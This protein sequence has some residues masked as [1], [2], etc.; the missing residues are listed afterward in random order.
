MCIQGPT[1]GHAVSLDEK[2]K[3]CEEQT[4]NGLWLNTRSRG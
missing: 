1:N 2:Q 3:P 4:Q